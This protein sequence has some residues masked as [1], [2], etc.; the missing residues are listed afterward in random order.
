MENKSKYDCI[1]RAHGI[2]VIVLISIL[3]LF[4]ICSIISIVCFFIPNNEAYL[5]WI[6]FVIPLLAIIIIAYEMKKILK[7]GKVLFF[8]NL[9]ITNGQN[10]RIFPKIEKNC[11]EFESYKL[12]SKLCS[13]C[14]EFTFTNGKKVL[15]SVMQYSKKQVIQILNEIKKRGG[16]QTQEVE[17]ERYYF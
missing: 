10:S 8:N 1:I 12:T 2:G 15:F 9:F 16:L 17:I 5:N 7:D 14:I 3:L 11:S 6:Y 4:I 13:L